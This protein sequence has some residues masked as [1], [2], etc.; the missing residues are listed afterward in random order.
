MGA[1]I[2]KGRIM[3]VTIEKQVDHEGTVYWVDYGERS[4]GYL[5]H[6]LYGDGHTL[7]FIGSFTIDEQ[8]DILTKL[9]DYLKT[10]PIK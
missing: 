7:Y 2:Q 9:R 6:S 8:I 3:E 5:E 1:P 4:A 10:N